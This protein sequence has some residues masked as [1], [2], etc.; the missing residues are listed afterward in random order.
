MEVNIDVRGAV[1]L[2]VFFTIVLFLV[3]VFKFATFSWWW[4]AAPLIVL[5]GILLLVGLVTFIMIAV[6]KLAQ[7]NRE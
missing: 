5:A 4:V 6:A 7:K 1:E 2:A 3:R